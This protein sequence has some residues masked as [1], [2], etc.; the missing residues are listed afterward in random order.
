MSIYILS[1]L[2]FWN[3]SF[4][5]KNTHFEMSI[6]TQIGFSSNLM[7]S[8]RVQQLDKSSWPS[9]I[10]IVC[11]LGKGSPMPETHIAPNHTPTIADFV[12]KCCTTGIWLMQLALDT[13]RQVGGYLD[14]EGGNR[15]CMVLE[16]TIGLKRLAYSRIDLSLCCSV[17]LHFK[18]I[19]E[20]QNHQTFCVSLVLVSFTLIYRAVCP[21]LVKHSTIITSEES[22]RDSK[23][24]VT[25]CLRTEGQ[26]S[27]Y[28]TCACVIHTIL[29]N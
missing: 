19:W 5:S 21:F 4:I 10:P 12:P 18:E 14:L 8:G 25:G 16:W 1:G 2:F 7:A 22:L 15:I 26:D 28:E 9:Q 29:L 13:T 20:T 23:L 3:Q 24:P 11:R 17:S 6:L 27:V